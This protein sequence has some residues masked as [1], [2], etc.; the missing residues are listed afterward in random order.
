MKYHMPY[1]ERCSRVRHI[2]PATLPEKPKE[3]PEA[4]TARRN[5]NIGR[6]R[7]LPLPKPSEIVQDKTGISLAR[8]VNNADKECV[9]CGQIYTARRVTSKL[10]D[11]CRDS[12]VRVSKK[13]EIVCEHCGK[14]RT[15]A[16]KPTQRFCS[17][18][19]ANAAARDPKLNR[20]CKVCGKEFR[21]KK[22]SQATC[23]RK[24]GLV[25]KRRNRGEQ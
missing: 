3:E 23:S 24:C 25:W 21:T 19:C 2:D 11:D 12:G 1:W 6:L 7:P 14:K 20:S 17:A 4:I 8:Q 9:S 22:Q 16:P 5:A 10:C 13:Y 15:D 18:E